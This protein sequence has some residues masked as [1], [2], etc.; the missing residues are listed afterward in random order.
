V[1]AGGGEH[2]TLL[3]LRGEHAEVALD[4]FSGPERS[5]V[6]VVK[7]EGFLRGAAPV[8]D[9]G[10]GLDGEDGVLW[11]GALVVGNGVDGLIEALLLNEGVDEG[12]ADRRLG[13]VAVYPGGVGGE[14]DLGREGLVVGEHEDAIVGLPGALFFY[15]SK[16]LSSRRGRGSYSGESGYL[17]LRLEAAMVEVSQV[18]LR[19]RGVFGAGDVVL[20]V[21]FSGGELERL[22]V[23][24][25]AKGVELWIG[26]IFGDERGE[27]GEGLGGWAR[28][29]GAQT[30]DVHE[31]VEGGLDGRSADDLLHPRRKVGMGL[32]S[33]S[34]E[35]YSGGRGEE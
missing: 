26:G 9:K 21:C 27:L 15:G 33:G 16:P 5:K 24:L 1:S 34:G 18:E 17:L 28:V 14:S 23:G 7:G 25:G 31:A 30:R 4:E 29:E 13:G 19:C 22:L 11:E 3:V 20:P 6:G 10:G 2:G 8:F 12:G 32:N 35:D